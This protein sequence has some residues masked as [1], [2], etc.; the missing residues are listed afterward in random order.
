MEIKQNDRII[1]IKEEFQTL[2][3]YKSSIVLR[4]SGVWEV[5]K[6]FFMFEDKNFNPTCFVKSP[7]LITN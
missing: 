1:D 7:F 2:A 6:I 3:D 4:L 5:S